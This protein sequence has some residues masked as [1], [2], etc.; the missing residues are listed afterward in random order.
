MELPF[1]I[2]KV[3]L[4]IPVTNPPSLRKGRSEDGNT[5]LGL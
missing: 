2:P 3:E 5:S 4:N 1:S